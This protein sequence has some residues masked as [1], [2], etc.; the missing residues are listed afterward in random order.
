MSVMKMPAKTRTLPA[1][2]QSLRDH[3]YA[4]HYL[5][6][7][8]INFTNMRS[9]LVGTGFEQLTWKADYTVEEQRTSEWG[10]R[11]D[12]TFDTLYDLITRRDTTTAPFLIGFS[13]L[14]THEP[15]DVPLHQ[16][17]DEVLNAFCYLDQCIGRLTDRLKQSPQWK[18]LLIVLLPDHS[19]NHGAYDEQHPDRNRIP[20]VWVGGAV[21]KP[22]MVTAICNQTD[23]PATLLAQMGIDH[24]TF[25]FSRDVMA[26]TYRRPFAIHTYNNGF[27]IADTT[28]FM[29][30]DLDAQRIIVNR[31]P[32]AERLARMGQAILQLTSENLQQR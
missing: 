4:T 26:D 13:T 12:I 30:Y 28:G 25:T 16:L 19:I 24:S 23:L 17:N 21:R 8:D 6:G 2:A 3:G 32:Q 22:T 18:D 14:S 20:M 5:Y 15:W 9:Y 11:D 27:S 31:S 1:L 10:V 29:A 7:G